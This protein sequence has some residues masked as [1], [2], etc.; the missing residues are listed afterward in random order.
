MPEVRYVKAIADALAE[1]MARDERVIVL[2]EDVGAPGGTFGATRGLYQQ[3]GKERVRDTPISET[4]IVGAAIGAAV[5]GLRP[6]VEVMFMDFIATCWDQVV[7]Q[8]A[9]MRYMFGGQVRL[10][11]VVRTHTGAGL[12]AGPQHSGS[13]EAWAVHVPGLKVVMPATPADAKGLLKAAIRDDNPVLVLENK[14]LYAMKGEVPA[15]EHVTPLG[16][17]EVRRGGSDVTIVALSRMVGEALRA[18]ETVAAEGI[19]AEVIDP[20][21]LAPLDRDT[22]LASVAKTGRLVVAHEAWAPCGVGAEIIALAAEHRGAPRVPRGASEGGGVWGAMSGPPTL[23][24][25]RVTPPHTPVPF[26]PPM[27]KLW[28]PDAARIAAAVREVMG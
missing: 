9:K 14:T 1:E 12:N 26:S 10:P 24:V 4:A 27:E 17:A 7:N 22:I 6:V 28:L 25:R 21:T 20:R 15:G 23:M 3:F 2:G 18:A 5:A 8:M 19:S 11:L 13:L 16:R